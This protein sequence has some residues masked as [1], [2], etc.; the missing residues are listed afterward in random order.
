MSEPIFTSVLLLF[1]EGEVRGA[2]IYNVYSWAA[3]WRGKN[4]MNY[5]SNRRP[6][7]A[8]FSLVEGMWAIQEKAG[9]TDGETIE[10]I[11][12]EGFGFLEGESNE[13]Q[14]ERGGDNRK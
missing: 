2:P 14:S 8:T 3:S 4:W 1:T 5:A 11:E 12:R 6:G 13:D 10:R 9:D 7:Y